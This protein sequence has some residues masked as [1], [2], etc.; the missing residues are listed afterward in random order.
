[1][2]LL[3]I[4]T[5]LSELIAVASIAT[6]MA[7]IPG[8]DFVMV[9]RN[10]IREGRFAGLSITLGICLSICIHA[11]Y[12][13][14]GIAVIVTQSVWLFAMIQYFGSAYLIYIG[15]S[16][17][18]NTQK[19]N[20]DLQVDSQPLSFFAALRL[21]FVTNMLNPKA[22]LFFLSIFTQVVSIDTPF[23]VQL[24]YAFI[25]VIAHFI[26][27]SLVSLLL[28]HPRLLP[29]F[30]YHKHSIDKLAGIILVGFAIKI[31]I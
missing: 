17:L 11:A 25:I 23:N 6:F 15:W 9:T 29:Y 24:I 1:M 31:L 7:I 18:K 3:Y 19:I 10:S 30:N 4:S 2:S 16:L 12:T 14:A 28:S 13:L 21:G 26:W 27:F 22:P 8:V 20:L 5:Y